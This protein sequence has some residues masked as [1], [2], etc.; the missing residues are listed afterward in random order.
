MPVKRRAARAASVA[1]REWYDWL[2]I[3]S[4]TTAEVFETIR[5]AGQE[6]HPAYAAGNLRLSCV[7]C[8]MG[9]KR[10]LA[11]GAKARPDLFAKYVEMEKRTG[12]T[13]HMSRKPLTQLVAE[14]AL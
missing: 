10:D 2:P 5:A 11:L 7:F 12:Y 4:L 1:G 6:P 3:H 9:D 8:I 13:L 14:A